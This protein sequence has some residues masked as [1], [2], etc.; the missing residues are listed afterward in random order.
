MSKLGDSQ[1]EE[2][3]N[4][5]VTEN[6]PVMKTPLPNPEIYNKVNDSTTSRRKGA[7]WK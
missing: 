2:L 1:K 7:Q 5:L 4:T 6:C 3:K